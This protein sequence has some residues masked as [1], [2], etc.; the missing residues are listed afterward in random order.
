[1]KVFV[2]ISNAAFLYREIRHHVSRD[3]SSGIICPVFVE[4]SFN[5]KKSGRKTFLPDAGQRSPATI[6]GMELTAGADHQDPPVGTASPKRV[7]TLGPTALALTATRRVTNAQALSLFSAVLHF[8]HGHPNWCCARP[9]SLSD[10]HSRLRP[11]SHR[12]SGSSQFPLFS[13]GFPFRLVR[14]ARISYLEHIRLE[15]YA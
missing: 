4:A 5:C 7:A 8:A 13:G 3:P 2:V 1:M 12:P 9:G 11:R 14:S 15:Q 10:L 6:A